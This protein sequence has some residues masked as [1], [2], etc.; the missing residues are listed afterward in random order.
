MLARFDQKRVIEPIKRG[1]KMRSLF[2]VVLILTLLSF[3][4]NTDAKEWSTPEA[5]RAFGEPGD[6]VNPALLE[7]HRKYGSNEHPAKKK[8][9]KAEQRKQVRN[10]NNSEQIQKKALNSTE[11]NKSECINVF[12]EA[13]NKTKENINHYEQMLYSMENR[14]YKTDLIASLNSDIYSLK[15]RLAEEQKGLLSCGGE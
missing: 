15:R 13:I 12:T 1:A 6:T 4:K 9:Q 10:S 11:R 5:L 8:K 2:F 14:N 3:S 7:K